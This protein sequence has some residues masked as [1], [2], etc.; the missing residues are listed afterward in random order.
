MKP[1]RLHINSINV[2]KCTEVIFYIYYVVIIIIIIVVVVVVVILSENICSLLHTEQYCVTEFPSTHEILSA[3]FK[4]IFSR[5]VEQEQS[6]CW[7]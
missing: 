7:K 1:S 4:F 5:I 3:P 2:T 6:F